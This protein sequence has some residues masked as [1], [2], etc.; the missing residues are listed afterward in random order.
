MGI[1]TW[2]SGRHFHENEVSCHFVE[3]NCQ[4]LS[5]VIKVKLSSE[6]EDFRRLPS[7]MSLTAS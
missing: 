1:Q 4:C 2:R 6:K 7:A 5:P 3:N